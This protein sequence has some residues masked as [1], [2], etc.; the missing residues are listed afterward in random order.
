MQVSIQEI[1]ESYL[2]Y[3]AKFDQA[4]TT[5]C[6][7]KFKRLLQADQ[8]AARSEAVV[9]S[10][11]HSLKLSPEPID[12]G[13]GGPDF[14]CHPLCFSNFYVEVT[15]LTQRK[16]A[17]D[18]GI[19]EVLKDCGGGNFGPITPTI[20]SKAIKKIPQLSGLPHPRL[21]AITGSHHMAYTLLCGFGRNLLTG[22]TITTITDTDN[23][24]ET[25]PQLF[26][27]EE[28]FFKSIFFTVQGLNI[29][30]DHQTISAILLMANY[31]SQCCV[32][33]LNHPEP[34]LSFDIHS[35]PDVPFCRFKSWP[36]INGI[37]E[38]EWVGPP[39]RPAIFDYARIQENILHI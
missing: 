4:H 23:D 14:L 21:I 10:L 25:I 36:I 3:L 11:L 37:I 32:I 28:E 7:K 9:F 31:D 27:Q 13:Q 33:G 12:R 34:H 35:M 38:T 24:I 18:S 29:T 8:E 17:K 20:L 22:D 26:Y 15:A 2:K 1:V 16:I 6:L 39:S 5:K 30:P 19:P